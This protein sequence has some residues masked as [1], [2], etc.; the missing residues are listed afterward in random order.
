MPEFDDCG[1]TF[2]SFKGF[3]KSYIEQKKVDEDVA[4]TLIGL[5]AK[6]DKLMKKQEK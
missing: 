4:Y 6:V 2:E 5:A 3:M 1:E